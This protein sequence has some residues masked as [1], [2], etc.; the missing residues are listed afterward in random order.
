VLHR[1]LL[2]RIEAEEDPVPHHGSPPVSLG[3]D[4]PGL[5][6]AGARFPEVCMTRPV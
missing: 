1:A 5:P 6:A 3:Y 4:V 2:L